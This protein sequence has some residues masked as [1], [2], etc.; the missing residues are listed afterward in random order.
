MMRTWTVRVVAGVAIGMMSV[1]AW[2]SVAGAAGAININACMTLNTPNTVYKL[3]QSLQT[4]GDC[5]VIA[6]N[7]ITVDMQ[8]FTITGTCALP[9]GSGITDNGVSLDLTVVK[10]GTITGFWAGVNLES[11]SRTS[12]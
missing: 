5:L 11:S 1:P 2:T 3:T 9:T 7:R 8:N 6:G 12:V 4:C 10:N